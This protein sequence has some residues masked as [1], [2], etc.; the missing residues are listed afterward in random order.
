M[1]STATNEAKNIHLNPKETEFKHKSPS[2]SSS[3]RNK[4][5][6]HP[7]K[8]NY[9]SKHHR[10][11]CK[12]C[13]PHLSSKSRKLLLSKASDEEIF[14]V[15]ECICNVVEK[16]CPIQKSTLKKLVPF[17]NQLLK[18][19]SGKSFASLTERRKILSQKGSGTFLPLI[20]SSVISYLMQKAIQ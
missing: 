1:N 2:S 18:L 14:A 20:A 19:G 17:K 6:H 11:I 8:S 15:C 7:N 5:H 10:F 16:H 9:L 13:S 3:N 4:N 12:V